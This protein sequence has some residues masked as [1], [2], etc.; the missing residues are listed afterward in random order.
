MFKRGDNKEAFYV[1]NSANRSC[2]VVAGRTPDLAVQPGM[3]IL[4][5]WR[6]GSGGRGP[7]R[8]S[9]GRSTVSSRFQC[10]VPTEHS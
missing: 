4:P 2:A 8:F 9:S 10:C 5:Q 1:D 3:G 6:T 7:T